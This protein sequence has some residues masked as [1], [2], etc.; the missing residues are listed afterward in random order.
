MTAIAAWSSGQQNLTGDG[1]PIRIGVGFVTANLFDVLGARPLMGRVMTAQEDVP[2]GA[3]V[4]VLGYPLWQSR[5]GGDPNVVGKTLMIND[6]P[7]QVIGVMPEGFRLPTDFN[8]E[9]AEPTQLWRPQQ[10]DMA[11][12]SRNHGYYA[13][14]T[15]APGQTAASAT[16]ELRAMTTRLTEQGAYPVAD[17]VHR[18]RR[19][20]RRGDSRR[21]QAGDVAADGRGR[22]PAADRVRERGEPA[23]GARRRAAARDGGA[24]GDRR[25]AGSP[26]APA[27]SPKAS[28]WR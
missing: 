21:R 16:E 9:A 11:E 19:A 15:L 8:D 12:L 7:V 25:R 13:V 22:V 14:A 1:E 24:H 10:W 26:G 18:V 28:C 20:D 5:Y 23:A 17:A 27:C 4:A 3:Q 2:N 6:V